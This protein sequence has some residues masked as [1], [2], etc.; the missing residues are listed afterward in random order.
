M[1]SCNTETQIVPKSDFF[2]WPDNTAHLLYTMNIQ[3]KATSNSIWI[4]GCGDIGRRVA[5]LYQK[6]GLQTRA[7]VRSPESV[8]LCKD[9][10]INAVSC[11]FDKPLTLDIN[12][13][14]NVQLFYF[15]PPPRTGKHDTR[16]EK[17]LKHIG[18]MP[19]RI[20]LISTT[21]VYGN[22]HG[23]WIDESHPLNPVAERAHRRLHAETLLQHWA[24]THQREYVILRVPGIYS[25][26]RLPIKRLL[27]KLPLV[28]E[29]EAPWTNRIHAD[30]LAMICKRAMEKAAS[31]EIYNVT[32]GNPS[33]MTTYFNKIADAT[34]L[35]RPEQIS[36]IK[37]KNVMSK[38]MISYL[39]ESRRIKNDKLLKDLG[40]VLQYPNLDQGLMY[41][42]V[43]PNKKPDNTFIP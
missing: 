14:N 33:T 31:T 38:G 9:I 32:D 1:L 11:D 17:F 6:Q 2:W 39:K 35:P 25:A 27:A 23:K 12:Q 10:H 26:D 37:A 4:A 19:A 22:C 30:D 36:L 13:F 5:R 29:S 28:R 24:K 20:V 21:G 42:N 8:Q 43:L 7:L 3:S 15:T 18:N 41:V 34:H 40:I 16:L